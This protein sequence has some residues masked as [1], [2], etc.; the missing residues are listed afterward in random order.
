MAYIK[1]DEAP[2]SEAGSSLPAD[3]PAS[4]DAESNEA[5]SEEARAMMRDV[6]KFTSLC[7]EA[8]RVLLAKIPPS[9]S[10]SLAETKLDEAKMWAGRAFIES[11]T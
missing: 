7:D 3:L 2:D 4:P 10:R 9:R 8:I 11:E 1:L 6:S 5:A